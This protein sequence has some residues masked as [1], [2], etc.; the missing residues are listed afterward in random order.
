M[1][2]E[3][4][5]TTKQNVTVVY[6]RGRLVFGPEATEFTRAVRQVLGVA[7]EIVLQMADVTHI[8]SSGVGA[9]GAAFTTAHKREAEI[10]L[11]ALHPR[12]VEVLRITGLEL[13]FDIRKSESEAVAAFLAKE[14]R[15]VILEGML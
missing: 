7:K 10:K 9:L 3:L 8:D 4:K 13:L 11:A 5:V 12:V 14:K 6:C 1:D 2:F 15:A